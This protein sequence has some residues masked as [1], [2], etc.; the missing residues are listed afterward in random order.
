MEQDRGGADAALEPD[1]EQ[2]VRDSMTC[3]SP[4]HARNLLAAVNCRL[5]STGIS[6]GTRG[7]FWEYLWIELNHAAKCSGLA[8]DQ[9]TA[10]TLRAVVNTSRREISHY[11]RLLAY[12]AKGS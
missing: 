11:R 4:A 2:L 6:V 3:S 9:E 12:E 8:L 1:R 10:R 5:L 7:T